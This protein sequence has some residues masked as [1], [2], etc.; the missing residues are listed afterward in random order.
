V[1]KLILLSRIMLI[2]AMVLVSPA[3]VRCDDTLQFTVPQ[4]D[5]G[6]PIYGPDFVDMSSSGLNGTVLSGQTLSLDLVLSNNVLA[7]LD[8]NDAQ[9]GVLLLIE[10]NAMTFP[11]FAGTTTGYFLDPS[12]NQLGATEV[13]GSGGCSCGE[14]SVGLNG[15]SGPPI[16]QADTSG[17]HFDITLPNSG[18]VVTNAELLYSPG[19]IDDSVQFGTVQQLPE[20]SSMMLTLIGA[21]LIAKIA[22]RRL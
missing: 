19:G 22:R 18:Y 5:I 1:R 3:I 10:T 15:F 11:G 7:R 6:M 8:F 20:P 14:L 2:F 13:A 21:G 12:G 17:V 9:F 4:S 16:L